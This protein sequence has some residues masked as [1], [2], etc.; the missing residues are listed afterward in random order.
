MD[1]KHFGICD[2]CNLNLDYNEQISYKVAQLK[3]KFNEFFKGKIEIFT[4]EQN[5]YRS[6]AEFG[7]YHDKDELY[8][9][10][11]DRYKKRVKIESCTKVD[12]NISALMPI[13]LEFIKANKS[14]KE[15]IFGAEFISASKEMTAI[16]LYH[17]NVDDIQSELKNLA[18]NLKSWEFP[19]NLIARSKGKKLIFG[20]ENLNDELVIGEK[21]FKYTFSDNAFLQPNKKVNEKMILWALSCVDDGKDF[22]EMY[23]G[24]GNFTIPLSFKFNKT[25]ATEIS[26]SSIKNAK[27]NCE[28]NEVTN[29]KFARISSEELMDAFAKKRDFNRLADVN[30]DQFHFSHILVDP[31]RS[32]LD[33][34][35][36]EFIKQYDNIIYISCNPDTMRENLAEICKT[37]QILRFAFF[38]Q[39]THTTH[40]E[41]GI[42]AVKI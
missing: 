12:K 17:K 40:M 2:S 1:C 11:Y 10:M 34:S 30:L 4:S 39:F 5:H 13:L 22:L 21:I 33:G 7:L 26:K 42:L 23:C 38:D 36:I 35:V 27:L 29:I 31:P 9:T 19:V 37:H 14:L 3:D 8:Y 24:H 15:K 20:N 18:K 6:R 28:L 41:C 25:L 16:L 32:G